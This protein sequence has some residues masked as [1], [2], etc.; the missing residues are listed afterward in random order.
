[1]L[2]V[3]GCLVEEETP[4]AWQEE[5]ITTTT[6]LVNEPQLVAASDARDAQHLLFLR[7]TFATYLR[8]EKGRGR[9]TSPSEYPHHHMDALFDSL[10]GEIVKRRCSDL[11]PTICVRSCTTT[12]SKW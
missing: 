10:S 9:S 6:Q 4:P 3:E 8:H 11:L 7:R 1:V 2:D 5:R 12:T